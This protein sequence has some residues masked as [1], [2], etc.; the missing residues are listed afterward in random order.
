MVMLLVIVAF[1][2]GL[3]VLCKI[4]KNPFQY[5]YFSY[6]FDVSGKRNVRVTDYIDRY[7][8]NYSNWQTIQNHQRDVDKWKQD[9]ESY[10]KRCH[11]RKRRMRQYK[12]TVDDEHAY[13][14]YATRSQTRYRQRNYVKSSYHVS[15]LENAAT[16]S[17]SWLS[18]RYNRLA[19]TGY[20]CTLKEYHSNSQRKLMTKELRR[21]IMI[22]DHYTCQICGKYMP[23]EVGLQIDHII[24][25][26]KGGKTVPSNLQVLCDKCNRRKSAKLS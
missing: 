8:C 21:Q 18:D 2:A 6:S 19:V 24:P 16:Y 26:S 15:T 5:P 20:S 25:V 4:L 1:I 13:R 3:L 23:D 9:C 17:Y 7:L 11:L 10:L 22:R 12:Q 14:F